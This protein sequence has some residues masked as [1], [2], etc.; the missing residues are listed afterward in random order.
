VNGEDLASRQIDDGMAWL[1]AE[2]SHDDYAV[3][4]F[5]ARAQ[6]IGMWT[7]GDALVHPE[8]WRAEQRRL[9]APPTPTPLATTLAELGSTVKLPSGDGA[10]GEAGTAI[11]NETIRGSR[12]ILPDTP[13]GRCVTGSLDELR[14]LV[15]SVRGSTSGLKLSGKASRAKRTRTECTEIIELARTIDSCRSE[16]RWEYQGSYLLDR[17][18]RA[19]SEGAWL[20]RSERV[21]E[22][23]LKLDRGDEHLIEARLAFEKALADK[24]KEAAEANTRP[25]PWHRY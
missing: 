23:W 14:A 7:D 6:R 4:L 13:Y 10:E 21:K 1:E 9:N 20:I 11:T 25:T 12:L 18:A 3:K 24:S 8:V 5:V 2:G 16:E 22:G 17:A 15:E 19:Y